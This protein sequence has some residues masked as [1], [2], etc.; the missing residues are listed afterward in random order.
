[1]A[2]SRL[3]AWHYGL[4]HL[5]VFDPSQIDL[6]RPGDILS[7]KALPGISSLIRSTLGMLHFG[8]IVSI[9]KK[10]KQNYDCDDVV[11]EQQPNWSPGMKREFLIQEAQEKMMGIQVVHYVKDKKRRISKVVETNMLYFIFEKLLPQNVAIQKR[12]EGENVYVLI[13]DD[14]L[15]ET[16]VQR[17]KESIGMKDYSI[18]FRNCEH[19]AQKVLY[20][21]NW[22][23]TQSIQIQAAI[24][25]F[26]LLLF[27][28][29][30]LLWKNKNSNSNN[31]SLAKT[32]V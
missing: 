6:L 25:V 21:K 12:S 14:E 32:T 15:R 1:M 5:N 18:M 22:D 13:Q 30:L 29:I 7:R 17:A 16:I 19:W 3:C 26:V 31:K 4:S 11:K 2:L 10:L 23:E 20:D 8:C 24:I 9:S 27:L 28:F